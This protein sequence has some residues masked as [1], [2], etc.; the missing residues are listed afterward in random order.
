MIILNIEN[1][2][3]I[4]IPH[5]MMK[6]HIGYQDKKQKN[7]KSTSDSRF[8]EPDPAAVGGVID[9]IYTDQP[10]DGIIIN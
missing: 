3:S 9:P 5:Y 10:S 1:F 6:Q 8:Q 7:K 4:N 2:S